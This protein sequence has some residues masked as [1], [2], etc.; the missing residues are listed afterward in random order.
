MGN[1]VITGLAS[2]SRGS[3]DSAVWRVRLL[4][5]QASP[6]HSLSRE[7]IFVVLEGAI[8]RTLR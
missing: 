5:D 2:P 8:H 6:P 1:A 7:E 3:R 4:T